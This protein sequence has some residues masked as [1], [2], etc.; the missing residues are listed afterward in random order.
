[1]LY[2]RSACVSLLVIGL[3]LA[4]SELLGAECICAKFP[5]MPYSGNLW[6]HYAIKTKDN[7]VDDH[8]VSQIQPYTQ[9]PENCTGTSCGTC[10]SLG[11]RVTVQ[12]VIASSLHFDNLSAYNQLD[13]ASE[14]RRF[15]SLQATSAGNTARLGAMDIESPIPG[16]SPPVVRLIRSNGTGTEAFHAVLWKI[17]PNTRTGDTWAYIGIEV[18]NAGPTVWTPA[19]DGTH[20]A[21]T[22]ASDADLIQP[23]AIKGLLEVKID[24]HLY[25]IRLHNSVSNRQND[26]FPKRQIR[27]P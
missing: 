16:Q 24:G 27:K 9:D 23:V 1:M 12:T 2:A 20:R 25:F 8:P 5:A 19:I 15:L 6:V 18:S 3:C 26:A 22:Y 17:R 11:G 7:C 21:I 14:V 13:E 10:T 4:E